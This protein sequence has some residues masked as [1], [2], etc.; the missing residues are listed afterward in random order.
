LLVFSAIQFYNQ[1]SPPGGIWFGFLYAQLHNNPYYPGYS[2]E[3]PLVWSILSIFGIAIFLV[4][5]ISD[6]VAKIRKKL[7]VEQGKIEEARLE[8]LKEILHRRKYEELSD[9]EKQI[10]NDTVLYYHML[11]GALIVMLTGYQENSSK[12]ASRYPRAYARGTG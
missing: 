5:T 10:Y 11:Q 1:D 2:E 12:L 4:G 9:V 8:A 3:G 6:P 7:L